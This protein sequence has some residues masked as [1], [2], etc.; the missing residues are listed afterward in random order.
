MPAP[1]TTASSTPAVP[2]PGGA[3]GAAAPAWA[4][5]TTGASRRERTTG[6]AARALLPLVGTLNIVAV[7]ALLTVRR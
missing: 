1:T 5:S 7:N 2:L 4:A 6:G 3:L